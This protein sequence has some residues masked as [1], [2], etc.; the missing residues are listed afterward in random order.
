[1]I[2]RF[3]SLW[4]GLF[5]VFESDELGSFVLGFCMLGIGFAVFSWFVWGA[6]G[7]RM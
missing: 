4:N 1:M 6:R 5:S 2:D 3:F 7:G